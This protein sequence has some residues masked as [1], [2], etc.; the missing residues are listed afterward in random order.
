MLIFN[1]KSIKITSLFC[2]F[3]ILCGCFSQIPLL[4]LSTLSSHRT[5]LTC[6]LPSLSLSLSLSY[7]CNFSVPLCHSL[8]PSLSLSLLS[9]KKKVYI[10]LTTDIQGRPHIS[11]T[12]PCNG[13]INHG[14]KIRG[15]RVFADHTLGNI[16]KQT[17]SMILSASLVLFSSF[18]MLPF[19]PYKFL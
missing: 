5:P 2:P 10:P 1:T 6:F 11:Y 12:T 8:P 15:D 3:V 4:L 7:F 16:C 13:L 19:L 17:A 18:F 9:D 14:A